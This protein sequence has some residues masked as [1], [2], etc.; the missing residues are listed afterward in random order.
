MR[1][2]ISGSSG[3]IG[4]ALVPHLRSAG[5]EVVRLVRRTPQAPDE[6]G[7]DPPSGRIDDGALDGADAVIN[8]SGAGHRRQAVDR[9]PQAGTARQPPRPHR[10]AGTGGR[11]ARHPRDGQR[12]GGGLLRRHRR[13]RGRRVRGPRTRLPR[14]PGPR[15]GER[16]RAGDRGGRA[17]RDDP[18]RARALPRGRAHGHHAAGLQ[19]RPRRPAGLRRAVL[20][21]DQPRRRGR[22]DHVRAGARHGRRARS[23]PPAPHR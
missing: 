19:V 9:R 15:L 14:R 10:R 2:V 5:H 16:H 6:R 12:V 18:H 17:G 13:G 22:R 4:T 20:A 3:L 11:G 21:V 8:L 1:V 7:W 23:T